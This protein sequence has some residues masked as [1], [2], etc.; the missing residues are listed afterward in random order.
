MSDPRASGRQLGDCGPAD[1]ADA[2]E[3]FGIELARE[4]AWKG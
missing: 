1:D 4:L 2:L 3:E